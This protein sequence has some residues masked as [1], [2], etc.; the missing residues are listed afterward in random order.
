MSPWFF[1]YRIMLQIHQS[2]LKSF[3]LLMEQHRLVTEMV[4]QIINSYKFCDKLMAGYTVFFW[5]ILSPQHSFNVF[6]EA[7]SKSLLLCLGPN[8]H[9]SLP[10]SLPSA[11][12]AP[13]MPMS[14]WLRLAQRPTWPSPVRRKSQAY[15]YQLDSLQ[16]IFV[17]HFKALDM[18]SFPHHCCRV[19]TIL[20]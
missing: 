17:T 12:G 1:C 15:R 10:P 14:S 11:S 6:T 3:E 4:S 20:A 16:F 5:P 18:H 9:H 7:G 8:K 13:S 2:F 19:G